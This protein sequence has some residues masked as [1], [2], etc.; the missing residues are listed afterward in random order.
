M[1]GKISVNQFGPSSEY[2]ELPSPSPCILIVLVQDRQISLRIILYCT[3][4]GGGFET[5]LASQKGTLHNCVECPNAR[6]PFIVST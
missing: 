6:I 2:P 3:S 4:G 1:M 5:V